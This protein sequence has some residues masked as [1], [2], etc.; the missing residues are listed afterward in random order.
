MSTLA[1][2]G[3]QIY[4]LDETGLTTV[5]KAPKVLAPK[6]LKQVGQVASRERGE[7]VTLCAIVS[8]AGQFL[9]PIFVYPRKNF[10]DSFL[11]GAPEGSLGLTSP[12][13]WMT[14][15]NFILVLQHMIK[16][17]RP[18][19]TH[20]IL[21][22]MDNHESHLSYEALVFAKENFIHIVTL[23]PHTSNKTQPLD[24]TVFGPL[25]AAF[26]AAADSWMLRNVGKPI[27]IYQIAELGG[28]A[29]VK[30]ATPSN[31]LSGFQ[32]SGIW[33]LNKD[34][35]T[36]IDFL[37][38]RI[39]DRPLDTT[40]PSSSSVIMPNS[41]NHASSYDEQIPH[42]NSISS[43]REASPSGKLVSE[44]AKSSDPVFISPEHFRGYPKAGPLKA[45]NTRRKKQSMIATSSPQIKTVRANKLA[46]KKKV[47]LH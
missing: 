14:G 28:G 40:L 36:E 25:K 6:G 33:P 45:R 23:P 39:T 37:P 3:G 20:Q 24:R 2:S 26:N 5:Q 16:Y 41:L 15:E 7:L 30:A 31:I 35:F 19:K 44:T 11:F 9:P 12:S 43:V 8:A 46:K 29:Y 1:L 13:G 17:V 18:T 27:S 34:V 4:N 42:S 22:I 47:G 21:L 10:R 32:A 38:C